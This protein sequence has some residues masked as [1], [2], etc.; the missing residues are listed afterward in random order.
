MTIIGGKDW[1]FFL[2]PGMPNKYNI[3]N[4]FIYFSSEKFHKVSHSKSE[5]FNTTAP[6][7][8]CNNTYDQFWRLH[9]NRLLSWT[10][11]NSSYCLQCILPVSMGTV[12][13]MKGLDVTHPLG[14]R[15]PPFW[16]QISFQPPITWLGYTVI[17]R[18]KK[19]KCYF[20]FC[21]ITN[22]K[23]NTQHSGLWR[24]ENLRAKGSCTQ[25]KKPI[26]FLLTIKYINKNSWI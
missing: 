21:R 6:A 8:C 23:N 10:R 14:W 1:H 20:V 16:F 13:T 7:L 25:C 22:H 11:L 2:N 18:T 9:M 24:S 3:S 12:S 26:R 15:H 17:C 5:A 4:C 19:F